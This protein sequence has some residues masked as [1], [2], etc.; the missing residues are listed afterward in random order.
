MAKRFIIVLVALG[1]VAAAIIG[2]KLFVGMKMAEVMS[3]PRPPA[4]IASAKVEVQSWQ[5]Y[6]HA[7]GSLVARDGVDVASRVDGQIRNINFD[8]GQS[9]K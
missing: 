5:P 3:W 1:V 9:V 6:L 8:S 2:W 7:L 4:V